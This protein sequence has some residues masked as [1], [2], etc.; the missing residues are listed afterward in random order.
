[1]IGLDARIGGRKFA[2]L[3]SLRLRSKGEPDLIR[4]RYFAK[5]GTGSWAVLDIGAGVKAI[6]QF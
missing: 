6:V 4:D 5:E 2:V 1:M 3:P